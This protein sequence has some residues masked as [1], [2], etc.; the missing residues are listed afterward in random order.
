MKL[1]D[2][3]GE[4]GLDLVGF[5]RGRGRGVNSQWIEYSKREIER[6]DEVGGGFW[7]ERVEYIREEVG[8]WLRYRS[9]ERDEIIDENVEGC[10]MY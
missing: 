3:L 8:W 9:L 5:K 10:G 6:G 4:L 2:D 7:Y 1:W